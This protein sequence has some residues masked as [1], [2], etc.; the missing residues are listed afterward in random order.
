MKPHG[1]A[2]QIRHNN[3]NDYFCLTVPPSPPTVHV[4]QTS[5]SSISL[6]WEV[7]D[8]GRSPVVKSVVNYKMTY[9]EW[10]SEEVGWHR[11]EHTL[12][13][14]QCGKEYH[15]Y[16]VLVN[17][18]GSSPTSEVLTVRTQGSRPTGPEQAEFVSSNVTFVSLRLD[19]WRD[20]GCRVL[21]FVVEY[22]LRNG[23]DRAWITVTNDLLPQPRYSIRG[24]IPDTEYDLR[25]T[26]HNHAGST[27]IGYRAR[28]LPENYSGATGPYGSG[29]GT[30]AGSGSGGGGGGVLGL[31]SIL[32]IVVS[33]LCLILA[34]VGVCVCLRKSKSWRRK[35]NQRI[36]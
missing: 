13:E 20:H 34:S 4:L 18:L 22:K 2:T 29:L 7:S 11:T 8:D 36:S 30:G 25:V 23:G 3:T 33:S 35:R 12:R 28:T 24:L 32:L 5:P 19:R 9:G 6:R 16:V 17:A 14:L 21:Y 10:S 31:R 15:T 26:A 27:A 1:S